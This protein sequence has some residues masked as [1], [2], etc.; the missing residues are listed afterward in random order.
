MLPAIPLPPT[1]IFLAPPP[2]HTRL[3]S[4]AKPAREISNWPPPK[5]CCC[6][7]HAHKLIEFPQGQLKS[8][9]SIS[10]TKSPPT[11]GMQAARL[12]AART[13][14]TMF[15]FHCAQVPILRG[16]V[17]VDHLLPG[18]NP[19]R[20]TNVGLV[21][22]A[23]CTKGPCGRG[24]IRSDLGDNDGALPTSICVHNNA[25]KVERC[26]SWYQSSKKR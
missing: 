13:A 1:W 15:T 2:A 22:L 25:P 4:S 16:S 10:S 21:V 24:I 5:L 9:G 20:N 19:N 12:S 8:L 17:L 7:L 23:V 14:M 6:N 26:S 18:L 11:L 3:K